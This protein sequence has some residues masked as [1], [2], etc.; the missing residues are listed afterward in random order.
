MC[1]SK[2]KKKKCETVCDIR[3]LSVKGGMVGKALSAFNWEIPTTGLE[4]GEADG[5][6]FGENPVLRGWRGGAACEYSM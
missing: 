3:E 4:E 1:V 2:K 6:N 5:N